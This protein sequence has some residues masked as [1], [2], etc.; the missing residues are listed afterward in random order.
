MA[1]KTYYRKPETVEAIGPISPDNQDEVAEWM[2]GRAEST[3]LPGPGRGLTEGVIIHTLDGRVALPYGDYLLRSA[4]GVFSTCGPEMFAKS[5]SEFHS[6]LDDSH[7]SVED[8][9]DALKAAD[10]SFTLRTGQ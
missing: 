10:I 3:A 1:P 4:D 7:F 9:I 6:L 8:I 5:Y 2:G